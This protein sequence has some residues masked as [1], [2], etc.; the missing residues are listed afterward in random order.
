MLL[1]ANLLALAVPFVLAGLLIGAMLTS[2]PGAANRIYGANLLGSGVGAFGAPP[3]IGAIG[4]DQTV[5]AAAA[6]GAAAAVVLAGSL[7]IAGMAAVVAV[8]LVGAPIVAPELFEPEPSP[9]K[10]LSQMRLDPEARILATREDAGVRLDIVA[11]STIHSAPG[12]SLSYRGD[13]PQQIGLVL[14]G[15]ALLPVPRGTS[16]SPELGDSVPSAVAREIRPEAR[17]LILGSGGGFPAHAALADGASEVTIVEPSRLVGTSLAGE[18]REWALLADDPRVNLV[19][20][21]IRAFAA[22]D[23]G[24]Y[25]VVELSLTDPYRPVTSGAYSLTE[26]YTLTSDAVAAYLGLLDEDGI[27][28]L[29]RWLQTPPTEELRTLGLIVTALGDRPAAD[30]VFAFRTFQTATY[31]VKPTPF[32]DAE[33]EALLAA[34][35]H[36]RYD[37]VLASHVP[38]E[39]VNRFAVVARPLF[40]EHATELATTADQG[41]FYAASAFEITPTTDDRP[42][43]FH[44]FRWAQTPDVLENLGRRWLP[45]GGS[46]YFV[47]VALLVFAVIAALTFVLAPIA[48]GRHFRSALTALGTRRAARTIAYFTALGLGFLLVEIALAQRAILI[49]GQAATAYAV[50]IGAL[51]VSSG[52]GSLLSR[53]LPWVVSMA[54]VALLAV[55]AAFGGGV[56]ADALLPH[57]LPVRIGGVALTLVPLG[58]LM[59]VPFARGVAAIGSHPAVVPWAWAANGSASVAAGVLAVLISLSFGLTAVLVVGA[60]CYLVALVTRPRE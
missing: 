52:L 1:I 12:L 32:T 53:R 7:R 47:L 33:T 8:A 18:L 20:D 36:L 5:L 26:T 17:T 45:F 9:Y 14:D 4:A 38:P 13:L 54:G 49:V 57:A 48:L 59:G 28:V 27:L 34:I 46:G 6:L 16:F 30:H 35:E 31:L 55:A 37:L 11:S 10:R 15:D 19:H 51:L 25:D 22:R 56:V 29:T 41:A 60:G 58:L 23:A 44:F 24:G 50:V 2:Q 21:D 3:V 39:A 42:F 43:F 40:H